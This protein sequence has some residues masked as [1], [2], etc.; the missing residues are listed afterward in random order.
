MHS[1]IEETSGK[2]T[3]E[4]DKKEWAI[5][6]FD[7]VCNLCSFAV[8]TLIK[9]DTKGKLQYASLQSEHAVLFL[10]YHIIGQNQQFS[11]LV[12]YKNGQTFTES[13]AVLEIALHIGGVWKMAWIGYLIPAFLRDAMYKFISRN[14]FRWFGKKQSCWLPEPAILQ[15]FL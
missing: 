5:V 12:F 6:F 7:G 10:P 14:R 2:S 4:N 3:S 11:T 15:R 8:Q 1:S 9:M 13:K